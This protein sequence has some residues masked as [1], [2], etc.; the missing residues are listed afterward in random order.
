MFSLRSRLFS[1]SPLVAAA[2]AAQASA[3]SA[4]PAAQPPAA[5]PPPPPQRLL[6][7]LDSLIFRALTPLM[8]SRL[9]AEHRNFGAKAPFGA[10]GEEEFDYIIVGGGSAGCVLAARLSETAS[11]RVLLLEAG[12]EDNHLFIKMPAAMVKLFSSP[13]VYDFHSVPQAQKGG[14]TVF[15]PQGRGL[16]GSSSV[17]AMAYLRGSAYDYD[18]WAAL[19]F[20]EWS[21]DAVLPYFAKSLAPLG[22]WRIAPVQRPHPLTQR[23]I[24]AF[25]DEVGLPVS[26]DFNAERHQREAVG[27]LHVNIADGQRHSLSDAF[28]SR[29]VLA[30]EN[31]YVRTGAQ[32]HRVLY[33]T[34]GSGGGG[35]GGGGSG[36]GAGRRASGVLVSQAGSGGSAAPAAVRLRAG[37]EVLLSSGTMTSPRLLMLSGIGDPATLAR[38]GIPLVHANAA[39]GQGLQDHPVFF[40]THLLRDASL[41]LDALQ[42][43]PLNALKFLQWLLF[44]DN[45]L[46]S[47]AEMTGYIR[48]SVAVGLGEPAPDLQI[49]FIKAIYLDHGKSGS[50]GRAGYALGPILLAPKSTGSV[51][52]SGPSIADPPVID[53][54]IFSDPSDFERVVEGSRLIRRVMQ[55]PALAAVNGEGGFLVPEPRPQQGAAGGGREAE[56]EEA[57]LREQVRKHTNTL[58]HPTST[59]AM[60]RVVDA[61]LRVQGVQGLRVV[62]ASVMPF[63]IRANTNA[64]TVMIAERAA[65]FIKMETAAK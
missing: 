1:F 2:A 65:D 19:G 32:V 14:G 39:V 48:S 5:A 53:F 54:G 13:Y 33:A 38:H 40:M 23:V 29:E 58:Y 12:E 59:C 50:G 20:P 61:R 49:G 3:A 16:G 18:A 55:G 60:G 24:Q 42:T 43:F 11:K 28:L 34:E 57:W 46:A 35:G 45:E 52:L 63:L 64:P 17:N 44:R 41:S 36:S 8:R 51:T 7:T 22:P 9:R 30:R 47:C 21:H 26:R 56:A 62:D 15:I 6:P 31:L 10:T 25:H 37:G 4:E 27:L